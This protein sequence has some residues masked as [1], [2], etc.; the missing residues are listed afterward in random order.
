MAI[1]PSTGGSIV[2][3]TN[4]AADPQ[5]F[6]SM[7]KLMNTSKDQFEK[8]K[9]DATT[10]SRQGIEALTKSGTILTQ[11]LEQFFK[12]CMSIAQTSAER[13]SEAFKQLLS[14]KTLN[15]FTEAQN[16]FA[17]QSFDELM[18]NATK[19]SEIS[20]KLATDVFEPIND[21]VSK[22]IKKASENLA[23]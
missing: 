22:G 10:T 9:S 2:P 8:L 19:L 15:E 23:A 4:F 16:K 13:Q 14:C 18:Q 5:S 3:F 1:K 6:Q 20:I 17:Q 12:T 21:E 11:G 7:E